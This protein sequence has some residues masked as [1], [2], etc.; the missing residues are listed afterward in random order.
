MR[1]IGG[2][3]RLSTALGWPVGVSL[4]ACDY[5]WRTTPVHRREHAGTA[6]ADAPPAFPEGVGA[7]EVQAAHAGVGALFHRRYRIHIRA[8]K[9]TPDELMRFIQEDVNRVSPTRF[10]RFFKTRGDAASMQVGDEFLIRM[11]GP[12]DGPVRVIEVGPAAFRLAT[13]DGH[14]E[15]GQIEFRASQGELL[16]FE[17]E[18]WARSGDRV[19]DALY[20]RLG[21]A[22]EVQLHMWLSFLERAVEASGG[23]RSGP[24]EVETRRV[25]R[26]PGADPHRGTPA[27][28]RELAVLREAAFN[29]EPLADPTSAAAAGWRVDHLSQPLPPEAPGTPEPHG[30]FAAA[31]KLMRG[32]EFV[33]PSIVQA[34]YDGD[35][36]LEGRTML[37]QIRFHGLR[38]HVGARV[39]EVYD[40]SVADGGRTATVWGWGYGTLAGH[41]EMG[42]MDWQVWKWED[43]GE[44]EFRIHAYSRRARIPNPVVRAG[45]RLVGRRE[46]LAF[47]HSTLR[48]MA[49]LT[50]LAVDPTAGREQIREAGEELT[51]R[52]GA[53]SGSQERLAQQVGDGA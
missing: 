38:F 5:L 26:D 27:I 37:L 42:R 50:A 35:E 12:W 48:R 47:L 16:E 11:A 41:F 53:T 18:S 45:F 49:V 31:Q 52:G 32:Y 22:K 14:L 33:D 9:R 2:A 4:T 23:R 39:L 1:G 25:E 7:D 19:A 40:R 51:A 28:R 46:Q 3:R 36:P 24:V 20:D 34:F 30:S 10:A 13:L 29:F 8:A 44:V 6:A 43:T 15:A 17:I 21:V